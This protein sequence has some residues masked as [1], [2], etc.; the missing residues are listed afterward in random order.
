M[1][2]PALLAVAEIRYL[3]Q[4]PPVDYKRS[5]CSVVENPRETGQT[6]EDCITEDLDPKTLQNNAPGGAKF[7]S[8]P[9]FM[10]SSSW[11]SGQEREFEQWIFETDTVSLRSSSALGVSVGP[12]VSDAEFSRLCRSAAE[13][14]AQAEAKKLET[15]FNSKK[16]TLEHRIETQELQ[17]QRYRQQMTTRGM[18]TALKIGESLFKLATKGRL[19]GVSSSSSKVRMTADARTR[20]KEAETV[21]ENYQED[22]KTLAGKFRERKTA[23]AG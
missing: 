13:A 2:T 15:A 5:L 23:A 21:L 11:W 10:T 9:D 16:T 1:Y 12:E 3:K 8:V 17:V 6:W 7:G 19:T 22:L 20:L 4:N 18:D 14:K